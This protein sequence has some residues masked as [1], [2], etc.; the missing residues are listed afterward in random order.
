MLNDRNSNSDSDY[1]FIYSNDEY[2]NLERKEQVMED[3]W[4][5][6]YPSLNELG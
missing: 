4:I 2:A 1:R 6:T 5:S 3:V